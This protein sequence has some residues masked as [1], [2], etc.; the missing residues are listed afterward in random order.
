MARRPIYPKYG[1]HHIGEY[2]KG[3]KLCFQCGMPRHLVMNCITI[4]SKQRI[5]LGRVFV[6]TKIEAK[7]SPSVI[8]GEIFIYTISLHTLIDFGTTYSF[9]SLA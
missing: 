8:S 1:K 5:V 7:A 6:M 2:L 9:A 3:K 4:S